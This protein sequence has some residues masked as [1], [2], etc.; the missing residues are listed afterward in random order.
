[1]STSTSQIQQDRISAYRRRRQPDSQSD[2]QARPWGDIAGAA[3]P[4]TAAPT[5]A[6]QPPPP[7]RGQPE[8]RVVPPTPTMGPISGGSAFGAAMRTGF[9]DMPGRDGVVNSPAPTYRQPRSDPPPPPPQMPSGYDM[10]PRSGSAAPAAHDVDIRSYIFDLEV[11]NRE[12]RKQLEAVNDSI[13]TSAAVALGSDDAKRDFLTNVLVQVE[14]IVEAH[15]NK[16]NAEIQKYKAEADQAKLALDQLREV[17]QTEGLDLTL[18]PAMIAFHKRQ[19]K[20]HAEGRGPAP[21]ALGI[22]FPKEVDDLLHQVAVDILTKLQA[23]TDRDQLGTT[24]KEAVRTGFQSIVI[25]FTD[26]VINATKKQEASIQTLAAELEAARHDVRTANWT[27]ETR[28]VELAAE[29]ALELDAMKDQLRVLSANMNSS[30]N[31]SHAMHEK[32]FAEYAQLLTEARREAAQLRKEIDAEK[33]RSAEVCLKLKAT[34]EKRREE[35][36]RDLVAKAEEVVAQRDRTL[37]ELETRLAKRESEFALKYA[38]KRDFQ[39]QAGEPLVTMPN[40][41]NFVPHIVNSLHKQSRVAAQ[42][43]ELFERDV[44]RKTQELLSKYAVNRD[45]GSSQ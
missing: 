21:S 34:L 19:Q 28:R 42:S 43:N 8:L 10:A 6:Q 18:A 17:I 29:Y 3:R 40:K 22:N 44:W 27:H 30:D 7:N 13:P 36:E 25:H 16:A 24:M 20:T 12:L 11:Q 45:G 32:A 14:G 35:F 1:M 4:L 9:N 23:V 26:E 15:R 2:S 33:T 41:E 39:A 31:L 37:A 38:E 5:T